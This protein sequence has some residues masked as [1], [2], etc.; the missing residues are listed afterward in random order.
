MQISPY[1]SE[2]GGYLFGQV[3][4]SQ[5]VIKVATLP[6]PGDTRMPRFLKRMKKR[7]QA[8][9]DRIWKASQGT[10]ILVGEWHTHYE[11]NPEPSPLDIKESARAFKKNISHLD[12]MVVVIVSSKS[13]VNSWVGV[14]R[15]KGLER[16]SRTG[17]KLWSD[18]FW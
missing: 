14:T 9:L 3:Y 16:I 6:G 18:K 1:H 12:F 13:V 15:G 2:S 17:Y 8:L 4:E 7:G 5:L 10:T 11:S